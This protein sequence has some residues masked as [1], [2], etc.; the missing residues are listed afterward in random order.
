VARGES[1]TI[2]LLGDGFSVSQAGE[3][4]DAGAVGDWIRV[5][6]LKNG[7]AQGD[8]M[9][10]RVSRPGEVVVELRD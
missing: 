2:A 9:R 10:A 6:G 4:M 8:A 1:V 7:Q 5:R 3:A